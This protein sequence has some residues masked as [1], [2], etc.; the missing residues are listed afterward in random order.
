MD[1][2][3][4]VLDV[5]DELNRI[6]NMPEDGYF[7]SAKDKA[8][9]LEVIRNIFCGLERQNQDKVLRCA[10]ESLLNQIPSVSEKAVLIAEVIE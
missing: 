8:Y 10:M 7:Q 1:K 5:I 6:N 3:E 9:R 2:N 4:H